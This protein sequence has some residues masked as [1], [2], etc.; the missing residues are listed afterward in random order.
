MRLLHLRPLQN[1]PFCGSKVSPPEINSGRYS[2]AFWITGQLKPYLAVIIELYV[3]LPVKNLK[4][5]FNRIQGVI[6]RNIRQAL[7][8]YLLGQL[9]DLPLDLTVF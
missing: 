6:L 3:Y 5:P 7:L 1:A 8:F 9:F 2:S 4:R